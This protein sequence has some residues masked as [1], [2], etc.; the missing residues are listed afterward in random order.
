MPDIERG[1]APQFVREEEGNT[2]V[3]NQILVELKKLNTYMSIM[4]DNI[5]SEQDIIESK[6]DIEA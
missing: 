1:F 6:E 4:T 2:D 3:L 5:I